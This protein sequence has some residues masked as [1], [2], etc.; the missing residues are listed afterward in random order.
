MEL[1]ITGRCSGGSMP[2]LRSLKRFWEHYYKHAA[3]DGASQRPHPPQ[4]SLSTR[5]V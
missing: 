5:L 2:L 3:P 4:W 1:R